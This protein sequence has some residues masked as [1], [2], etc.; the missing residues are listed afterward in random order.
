MIEEIK[1]E[2]EDWV[3]ASEL[4]FNGRS[5]YQTRRK[6]ILNTFNYF[7]VNPHTKRSP[8]EAAGVF[9]AICQ[10]APE[11]IKNKILLLSL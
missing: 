7:F 6:V 5:L 2:L 8:T 9:L 11:S 4:V 1:K 10:D 3:A